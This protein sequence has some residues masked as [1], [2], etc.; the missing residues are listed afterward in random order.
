MI[1]EQWLEQ[2]F[3]KDWQIINL[4][5]SKKSVL[6][7]I[8]KDDDNTAILK[9]GSYIIISFD[10]NDSKIKLGTNSGLEYKVNSKVLRFVKNEL[11]PI[12]PS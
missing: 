3:V 2:N 9:S 6:S 7:K 5:I 10:S 4:Q 8:K 12:T 1:K 11:P